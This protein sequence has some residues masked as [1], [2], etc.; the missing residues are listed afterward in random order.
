[1]LVSGAATH[2]VSALI[3]RALVGRGSGLSS[4][5]G[6]P[7]N[8]ILAMTP[9]YSIVLIALLVS[10]NQYMLLLFK[11]IQIRQNKLMSYSTEVINHC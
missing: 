5:L 6:A 9:A 2:N 3:A 4:L 10:L 11:R 7:T 8:L 1:M